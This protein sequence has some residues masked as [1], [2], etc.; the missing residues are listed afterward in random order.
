MDE[1]LEHLR[2]VLARAPERARRLVEHILQ[3]GQVTTEELRDLYGYDHPPRAARDAK[4]AGIPLVST[5]VKNA[6]G[7]W[8]AAY[9]LG[10]LSRIRRLTGRQNLPKR[11]KRVLSEQYG[12]KC[13]LCQAAFP[14]RLLQVDHRV[15]YEIAGDIADPM[16]HLGEFMLLCGPCN[17]AKS[18]SCEHCPNWQEDRKPEICRKCYWANPESY[19]H[20]G[21]RQLRRLEL[22]RTDAEIAVYERLV[23]KAQQSNQQ[24][25]DFVKSVLQRLTEE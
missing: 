16:Q 19:Q 14:L 22:V 8:I 24:L 7:R 9:K 15:P 18:W 2:S 12:D 11:L 23:R 25:P 13:H 10:D 20:I 3:H 17:R 5:R 1:E 21:L 4:E 6:Q